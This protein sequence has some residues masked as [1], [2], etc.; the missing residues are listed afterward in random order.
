MQSRVKILGHALHPM[1]VPFPIA[2][3][4]ATLVCFITY[5]VNYNKFWFHVGF[6]SNCAAVVI[7]VLAV[8]PGLID[9]LFIP[10]S[11]DAKST[12]LKH[13]AANVITLGLFTANAIVTYSEINEAKPQAF[14]HIIMTSIGFLVMLY[15]G[16]KGWKLVQTH[17][18]GIDMHTNQETPKEENIEKNASEI[19]TNASRH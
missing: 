6:I 7:S 9:W 10:G 4:T 19:F 2:F 3:N 16:F 8:V 5:A 18:I 1:I 12:G 15:A 14:A 13:M 17:H 11:S